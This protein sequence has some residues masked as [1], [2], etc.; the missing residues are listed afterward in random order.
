MVL[1]ILFVPFHYNSVTLSILSATQ[2][3]ILSSLI[4]TSN[5]SSNL[6]PST[7]FIVFIF[8]LLPFPEFF[9]KKSFYFKTLT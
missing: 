5:K 8:S 3:V 7:I 9:K 1:P 2:V 6:E 4:F